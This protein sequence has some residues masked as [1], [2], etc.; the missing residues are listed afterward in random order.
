M[1]QMMWLL[2]AILCAAALPACSPAERPEFAIYL[3][4][5]DVTTIEAMATAIDAIPL[6]EPPALADAD[7]V[8]Y[9]LS[10]HLLEVTPAAL[11]RLQGLRVPVSGRPFVVCVGEE[12]IYTGAFWTP[13]SSLIFDGVTIWQP[14]GS[15][16]PIIRIEFGYPSAA[17]A[18]GDD[19][20][21]DSR[22][23]TALRQA[24]KLH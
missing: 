5:E 12:R 24:G 16:E 20:R 14:L 2:L 17:H 7:I 10:S 4:A 15:V 6:D 22:I 19:P 21:S 8:S 11:E 9:T 3:A 1:K 13:I 23:I 18:S